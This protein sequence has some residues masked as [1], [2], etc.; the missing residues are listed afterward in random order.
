MHRSRTSLGT[1]PQR[2]RWSFVL[3]D[4][5]EIVARY[6][7][8]GIPVLHVGGHYGEEAELYERNGLRDVTWVEANPETI[9][10]LRDHVEPL[11]HRVIQA[12]LADRATALPFH[13][14]SNEG[15]SSS[16]LE[17]GTHRDEYPEV[18]VTRSITLRARTLD[19]LCASEQVA[20]FGLLVM[21][22]EGAQLHV[23]KGATE[24]LKHVDYICLEVNETPL[25]RG[26]ALVTD[27]DAY[28][29]DF[30]RVETVMTP[31][32]WGDALFVRKSV[33]VRELPHLVPQLSSELQ[34]VKAEKAMI[35]A[36]RATELSRVQS[37]LA[38]LR[39]QNDAFL[40][41]RSW[42]VTAPLRK[43]GELVRHLR[44]RRGRTDGAGGSR[45]LDKRHD[46]VS[47]E[48]N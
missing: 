11:G 46:E 4:L 35:N 17:L 24:E 21:D 12:L 47:A 45:N 29:A 42:R 9:P 8:T 6:K 23:L 41:S 34:I 40:A 22:V 1:Y 18:L 26:C 28:L 10:V 39:A 7:I 31:H 2:V 48:A 14:T 44:D 13:I 37:E 3:L 15:L 30:C 20:E 27:I 5:D 19:E 32:A 16:I 36:E 38:A 25:Y 43:F 33:L